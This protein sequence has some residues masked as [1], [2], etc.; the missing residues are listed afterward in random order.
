VST[1][2]ARLALVGAGCLGFLVACAT[3]RGGLLSSE[4]FGDVRLYALQGRRMLDGQVPYRDFF[5]E[6]P[7][8]SL[9]AFVLPAVVSVAHYAV[10]FKTLMAL[11]GV[12]T[13]VLVERVAAALGYPLARTAVALGALALAP[14]AVGPLIVNEYDLWPALL[15]VAAL[16][17]L[18]RGH[19]RLGCALLGLGAATKIFPLAVL[20]VALAWIYRRS[21]A[22]AL[23][24]ALVA[25]VATAAATYVAFVAVAPGGVWYS[26]EVQAR[27]GLQKE[28]LGAALLYVL[29]Q[30]HL[31]KAHIVVGNPNWTELT[32]PAGDTLAL[33][34][35]VAQVVAVALVAVL[36]TRRGP[37]P[38]TLAVA[39]AA[40]VTGFVA[41]GKVFSPQYL[42][43]L[44]PLVPL[45]GGAFEIAALAA[46]LV[47]TQLWFL[48][49]VNPF[50]L[51]GEV[52]LFITRDLLVAAL[53]AAL[54]VRLARIAVVRRV[55]ERAP[56]AG[57]SAPAEPT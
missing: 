43:W 6:Y 46:A 55:G 18:V 3:I 35:T 15:T 38:R 20:V 29:D 19:E 11:C 53:F 22:Q 36:V 17:A 45:V 14:V 30:L 39:T 50:D 57:G 7:P 8:G 24:R 25:A 5:V 51:H 32:G 33:L 26:L 9:V 48:Q 12:A 49:A 1:H 44:V 4:Q 41:F 28:S 27:R 21:G 10:L 16:L 42:I 13:V 40:A 31:Y 2:R 54:V 52:W 34:S 47:L 23:R 56:R 37:E